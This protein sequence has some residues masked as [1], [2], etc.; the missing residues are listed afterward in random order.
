MTFLP[1]PSSLTSYLPP[2]P[3]LPIMT[4]YLCPAP[5]TLLPDLL[6]ATYS[7]TSYYDLPTCALLPAPSSL[8]SYL[9]PTPKLPIMTFLPVPCSLPCSEPYCSVSPCPLSR[10]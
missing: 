6:P 7:Q 1:V 2:T 10:P 5:C 8:T 3:K 4:L 9:P